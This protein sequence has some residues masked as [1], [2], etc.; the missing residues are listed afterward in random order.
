M[1]RDHFSLAW[2]SV[3]SVFYAVVFLSMASYLY[4][5]GRHG[6]EG[7][8]VL[9]GK[10]L[11]FLIITVP[12]IFSKHWITIFWSA[13]AVALLWMGIRLGRR[14]LI[15]GAYGLLGLALFK[16]LLYDY[17]EVFHFNL[18]NFAYSGSYAYLLL[19]R[20]VTTFVVLVGLAKAGD[21]AGKA[22]LGVLSARRND[23]AVISAAMGIFLFIALN[24]ETAAF[25]HDYLIQA[26]FAAVSVLW[27]L[28]SVA[29]M[30]LGFRKNSAAARKV[31]FTLFSLTV[32][33]V[34]F[35]DMANFS[36]PYRII[37][38]IILGL[39]LVGTSYLYYKYKDRIISAIAD[40]KEEQ[41]Q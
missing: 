7:F 38:F 12:L 25:F 19:E 11:L 23:S 31:S 40:D 35:F 10:A 20:W 37:S 8:V 2:V 34:F 15:N 14:G 4:Q 13:Q 5:K 3:I 41:A 36:T 24:L 32:L 1:V 39:M 26:R 21:M 22:S 33:K 30:L 16:F 9:L 29:F 18:Y 28:F 6:H 27:T 17:G